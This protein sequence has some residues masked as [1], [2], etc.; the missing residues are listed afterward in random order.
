MCAT[1]PSVA[2]TVVLL[3]FV[4]LA[5]DQVLDPRE[6]SSAIAIGQS[7]VEAER[8]RFHQPYR[9]PV[10][11]PPIDSIEF[12]TPFRRVVLAAEAQVRIGNRVFTQRE[13]LAIAAGGG[14]PFDVL[15]E[16]TFHP[17]N[18]FVAVPAYEVMLVTG[19][20]SSAV[21]P[22]AVDRVPRF[23]LGSL[24][25]QQPGS[26]EPLVGGTITASFNGDAL[27]ASGIYDVVIR[28]SGKELARV[29]L[30]LARLR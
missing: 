27:N 17:L 7:P 6:V 23:G 28:E 26:G 12:V 25:R 11:R 19:G 2:H 15:V 16:A 14:S 24:G 5:Y 29:R 20:T 3:L 30:D 10:N 8:V 1:I 13:G 18:T 21:L 4:A 9:V 22:T